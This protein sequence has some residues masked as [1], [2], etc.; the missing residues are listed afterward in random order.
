MGLT[1]IAFFRAALYNISHTH[2]NVPH[3]FPVAG[4][5]K[6]IIFHSGSNMVQIGVNSAKGDI[7][8]RTIE[9]CSFMLTSCVTKQTYTP[10][11]LLHC[12]HIHP[13]PAQIDLLVN[14]EYC[15]GYE[16]CKWN[17]LAFGRSAEMYIS[18]IWEH[19]SHT[20]G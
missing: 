7:W 15:T 8:H 3:I 9:L 6:D 14:R 10:L 20:S 18:K 17:Y 13:T 19:F 1:R 5:R 11:F 2:H 12:T 16:F 4:T